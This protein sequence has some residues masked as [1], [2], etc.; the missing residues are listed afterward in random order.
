MTVL[1]LFC[2]SAGAQT[3]LLS[4]PCSRPAIA[5]LDPYYEACREAWEGPGP[6]KIP[7]FIG[8]LSLSVGSSHVCPL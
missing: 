6:S 2:A 8:D 3:S 5:M 4:C 7:L 1:S